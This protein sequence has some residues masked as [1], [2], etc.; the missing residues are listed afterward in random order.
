[1]TLSKNN[2]GYTLVEIV[3]AITLLA[4]ALPP[5]LMWFSRI[6]ETGAASANMPTVTFLGTSLME[7]IQSRKFD[8]L[9]EKDG[10]GNWSTVL[11]PDAGEAGNKNNFDDVDDFNG[12]AQGFGASFP[13][14]TATIAVSYVSS[15]DLNT[16]LVIPQQVPE[17]WTPSYKLIVVQIAHPSLTTNQVI[18]TI[19]TEAQSL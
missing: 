2:A 5:F 12:W 8:E 15:S 10:N 9:S 1:M 17:D 6:S 19:V 4:I 13:N 11:G 16:A 3:L 7:E 18:T 14:Y